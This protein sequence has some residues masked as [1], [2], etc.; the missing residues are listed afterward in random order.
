MKAVM[1][2]VASAVALC[3]L[4]AAAAPEVSFS[5]FLDADAWANLEGDYFANNELDIGMV[6]KFSDKVAAHVYAT[7]WT[8][9]GPAGYEGTVP[10]GVSLA[11]DRW[12][13]LTYDG[14]DITFETGAGSF[15]VGD[16][17]YQ[18]GK[19]NYY[20]YKRKSMITPESFSR[21]L[22][23]SF[24]GD[25]V[26]QQ[27]LLG[28]SDLNSSTADV[29]SVTS[30]ALG[31]AHSL[32]IY[33]GLQNDAKLPSDMTNVV[34]G[35][36]EYL[37]AAGEVLSLKFDFGFNSLPDN[38]RAGVFSLLFEPSLSLGNVS[39]AVT[40]FALF[41]DDSMVNSAAGLF[42]LGDEFFVYVEPGYSFTERFAFGLP[43]EIHGFDMSNEDDN[44]FWAVPTFYVYPFENVEWWIWFQTAKP[45]SDKDTYFG[46]GSEI[47]VNF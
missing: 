40:V 7:A 6:L 38:E 2:S 26:S 12:V 11:N 20:L 44:E 35:G 1:R 34:Y 9:Y 27:F 47:I 25:K 32:G 19:F 10:A 29:Q 14:F 45:L 46:A 39:T 16:L 28:I 43:L 42:N 31:E 5:G 36:L 17:V 37:G 41:D 23:F 13:S 21:G 24:G 15:S 22:S 8:V 18:F 4:A 3:A 33:L 30:V